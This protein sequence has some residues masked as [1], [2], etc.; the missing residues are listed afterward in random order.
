KSIANGMRAGR[1]SGARSGVRTSRPKANRN[2][3][4]REID[5]AGGNEKGRN[6]TRATF[7]KLLVLAFNDRETADAG[8]DKNTRSLRQFGTDGQAG[9]L[10]CV[11]GR[12]NSIVD[13]GVHLL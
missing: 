2:L 5:D 1:A 4:C 12:R 8:S 11:I 13:E 6:L 7:E 3:S 9:L 10:H